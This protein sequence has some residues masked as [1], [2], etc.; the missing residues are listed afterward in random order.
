MQRLNMFKHGQRALKLTAL[1]CLSFATALPAAQAAPWGYNGNVGP[2]HWGDLHPD[3]IV[4]GMGQNQSPINIQGAL[5]AKLAPLTVSYPESGQTIVNNGHT[6]QVDFAPGNTLTLNGASFN[7]A[8]VH[9][10]APSEN[11]IDGKTFPLEAHFVHVD[12]HGGLAVVAVMFEHGPANAGLAR[13]WAQMPKQMNTPAR[14]P[15]KVTPFDLLPASLAYYRYSGSL[16]TP[17]CSE[18]VRWLVLKTP[19]T[20]SQKQI[21]AF[22]GAM[23]THTNRPVQP[24][25]A[26]VVVE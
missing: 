7:M 23:G 2:Q 9:F 13:L 5:E 20:A 10:H 15:A 21:D 24:L 26:R 22:S 18:G 8:Q 3:Y 12:K 19:V 1:A 14:L 25:N 17:P 11:Q 16:T 4:C 6:L